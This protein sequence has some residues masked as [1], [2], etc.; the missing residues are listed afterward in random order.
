[1][2]KKVSNIVFNTIMA[3][4]PVLMYVFMSQAYLTMSLGRLSTSENGYNCISFDGEAALDMN[5]VCLIVISVF[6]AILI[7][8][9]LYSLF[10]GAKTEKFVGIIKLVSVVVIAVAALISV[11][12][13]ATEVNEL[14][15]VGWAAIVNLIVA[16]IAV[17]AYILSKLKFF[18]K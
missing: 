11:I 4:C 9:S 5:A 10:R 17:V 2:K 3:L 16:V 12:C 14:V 15:S 18:N 1:M 6:A 13:L 8:A 7:I